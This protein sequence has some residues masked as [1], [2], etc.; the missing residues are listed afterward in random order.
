MNNKYPLKDESGKT[1]FVFEKH[2]KVYGHIVRNR[3]DKEPAKL[4]FETEKFDSVEA[5]Q[6]EYP[7]EEKDQEG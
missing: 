3:T 7:P 6:T 5:L 1:M 2:G 4:L